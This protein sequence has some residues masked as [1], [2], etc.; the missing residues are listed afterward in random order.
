MHQGIYNGDEV[1]YIITDTSDEDY[2]NI[3]SKKQEW[4]IQLSK[5]HIIK[6]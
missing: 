5:I 2:A 3:I 6:L 4:N 1:F